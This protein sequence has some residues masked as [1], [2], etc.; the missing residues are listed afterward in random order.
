MT[1]R[2]IWIAMAICLAACLA[3][4][5]QAQT[6]APATASAPAQPGQ[7]VAVIVGA[8]PGSSVYARRYQ[9]WIKRFHAH[10]TKAGVPGK[11]IVVLTGDKNFKDPI[12][13]GQATTQSIT[14]TIADLGGK[15]GP[16][17]Q[18][19]LIV[20]GH[21]STT[22]ALPALVLP[23][24]DMT[25]DDLAKAMAGVQ[26]GNQVVLNFSGSSG[27]FLKPLEA[28]GRVNIA[29][30]GGDEQGE[31]VLAEF[32]LKA[33]ETGA[34]DGEGS[35][36][37][38]GNVSLLEALNW[39]SYQTALFIS[40]QKLG[41]EGGAWDVAGKESV[42]LFKKLYGGTAGEEGYRPLA[43]S[44]DA[45]AEDAIVEIQ[46]PKEA[47]AAKAWGSRRMVDEHAVLEDMGLDSALSPLR[48]TGYQ[49][50]VPDKPDALGA[51]AAKT[52]LGKCAGGH[53]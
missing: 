46:P 10:L 51:L 17:D 50:I 19:I 27:G 12:V 42:A 16:Q 28:K 44:S 4:L 53:P 48:G 52:F 7:C 8:M 13:T 38:D 2:R 9:D 23:G 32:F 26:A 31:P 20:I 35:Q 40:R 15:C 14:K 34:A 18:F 1:K 36:P 5:S 45:S 30:T 22:D 33:I 39:S 11:N 43:D 25:S 37:K 29:A 6:S 21:G 24:P 47:A 41:A 3:P 49:P